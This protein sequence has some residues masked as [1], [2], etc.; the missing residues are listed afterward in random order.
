[1]KY[2]LVSDCEI[3]HTAKTIREILS[4]KKQYK[5]NWSTIYEIK[6]VPDGN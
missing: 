4:Y 6:E 2:I 1:M 5:L 3:A